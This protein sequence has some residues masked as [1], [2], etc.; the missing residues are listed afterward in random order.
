MADVSSDSDNTSRLNRSYLRSVNEELERVLTSDEF[1]GSK[2]LCKFL[3]FVVMETLAGRADQIKE[4]VIG[5]EVFSKPGFDP[6][7]DASVRIV[8]NRVRKTLKSYYL[9][10]GKA[11]A[12][13]IEIPIG[14]YV[15]T[16]IVAP[17]PEESEVTR[18][19]EP[20]RYSPALYLAIALSLLGLIWTAALVWRT[21]DSPAR[22]VAIHW[23]RILANATSE[24]RSPQLIRLSYNADRL[25]ASPDERTVY[26]ASTWS[27]LLTV[28]S[29]KDD[30]SII[31]TLPQDGGP[32]AVSPDNAK[33]YVG[34]RTG[35]VM[36]VDT[37]AD[38]SKPRLVHTAGPVWDLA[39][40]PDG[41]KLFVAMG[42]RGVWRF[43]TKDW[44]ARQL[45]NQGCPEN[46]KLGPDGRILVV[47]YQCGGPEGV[48]GHDSVELFDTRSEEKVGT[49]PLPGKP[50]VGGPSSF[51]PDGHSILL[52]GLDA[53]S[54][55]DL[56]QE[57][58][59]W[60]PSHVFHFVGLPD[61]RV[62]KSL[63]MPLQ[64]ES[65]QFIDPTRVLF[66]GMSI[67]VLNAARYAPVESWRPT[68]LRSGDSEHAF[69]ATTFL[70]NH[71]RAYINDR[72]HAEIIVLDAEP[73]DC[74][75]ASKEPVAFY[76]GDG[77]VADV[78]GESALSLVGGVQFAPG[79]VGQAFAFDGTSGH[80]VAQP[81]GHYRFGYRDSSLA[82]Y[83]KFTGLAGTMTILDRKSLDGRPSARLA[84]ALDNS[85]TLQFGVTDGAPVLLNS[86]TK[87]V[88][89]RWYHIAVTKSDKE[90]AMYLDGKLEHRQELKG[91][92][93]V[94]LSPFYLGA[95]WDGKAFLRGKLDEILFY[96][97]SLTGNEVQSLY[98]ARASGSCR[99]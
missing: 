67:Q 39:V 52:D 31:R 85:L 43:Q 25:A 38:R 1:A 92:P 34:S 53:C 44:A 48:T 24:G 20:P 95:T 99:I 3:S 79:R 6:R 15:P 96:D 47:V 84:K 17:R 10:P 16:F 80:L 22:A 27:P 50:F 87:V 49:I 94:E 62:H 41:S 88:K 42:D 13:R 11:N 21:H 63:G 71:R 74:V 59:P 19:S 35:G 37:R 51:A 12:I 55:P 64:T 4:S 89:D 30:T 82:L 72:N 75:P 8:A 97:S 45:T 23:G 78:T 5:I 91:L 76:P 65:A 2:R 56:N 18:V 32:L 29:T 46:L 70:P 36:V 93:S 73:A 40:T 33:L 77:V 83:V 60:S 69:Q 14:H 98:E 66:I 54:R 26:A 28:I 58:C 9:G 61:R 90:L 86:R 81:T 57:A 68:D 7:S